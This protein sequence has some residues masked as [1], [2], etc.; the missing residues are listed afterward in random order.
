MQ[1]THVPRTKV[2]GRDEAS[3]GFYR[4]SLGIIKQDILGAFNHFHN[5]C[6]MHCRSPHQH[7]Q[8]H[9]IPP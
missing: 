9:Y 7:V 2:Q 5:N 1:S 8:E 3:M 6:H 4:K